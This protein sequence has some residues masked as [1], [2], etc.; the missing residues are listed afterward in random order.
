MRV[1]AGILIMVFILAVLWRPESRAAPIYLALM[2][3]IMCT[4]ILTACD[5]GP[6]TETF[7]A[8]D[9]GSQDTGEWRTRTERGA[10]IVRTATYYDAHHNSHGGNCVAWSSDIVHEKRQRVTCSKVRW[11]SQ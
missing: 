7:F 2:L 9:C 1:L 11:V 4:L 10:C 6:R 3:I 5:P 8:S